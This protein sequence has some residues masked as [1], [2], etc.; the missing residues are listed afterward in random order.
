MTSAATAARKIIVYIGAFSMPDKNAA[1]QR[2]LSNGKLLVNLGYEVAYFGVDADLA[3]GSSV[4]PINIGEG[5]TSYPAP[6][7]T[8]GLCSSFK[9]LFLGAE[10]E[11]TILEMDGDIA[12]VICYN[13]PALAQLQVKRLTRNIN[14]KFICDVTEWYSSSGGS[15]AYRLIKRLDTAARMR[16]VNKLADGLITTSCVVTSYYQAS[17][18]SPIVELPT[19][20]DSSLLS[21]YYYD[22]GKYKKFGPIRFVYAGTPFSIAHIDRERKNIKDRVDELVLFAL[23]L[24]EQRL[25]CQFDIYGINRE[26]YLAVFPEH[27]AALSAL[28]GVLT[29]KGRV[30]YS[31]VLTAVACADFTIFFRTQCRVTESG[32]PSKMTE[33]L[34]LGTPVITNRLENLRP[35]EHISGLILGDS[36]DDP[37]L[38]SDVL[39]M[40][41]RSVES[42]LHEAIKWREMFDYRRYEGAMKK[43]LAAV[44]S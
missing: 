15:L 4:K 34:A 39:N 43:F 8:A 26:Q 13:Y 21:S 40:Q 16:Y 30:P 6:A 24:H 12:A 32:L 10:A 37:K 42:R 2:V 23:Q 11:K 19:L 9:Q 25:P 5:L 29:F 28:N 31:K 36:F 3:H 14:A 18:I 27:E 44:M 35:Y 1:A 7:A 17:G 41:R 20:Q 38:V 33:S 22:K